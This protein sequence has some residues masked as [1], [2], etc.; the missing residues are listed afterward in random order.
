MNLR[1][2]DHTA[3][4]VHDLDEAIGRYR[5]LFHVLPSERAEVADQ[6][7]AVAFLPLGNSQIELISPTDSESGV[8]RFLERRG[9][10]LHHIAFAVDDIHLELDRLSSEGVEL[11]DREPRWGIHGLIAFVHPRGTG[12]VLV[13][14]VEH[15]S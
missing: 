9:E 15:P 14:L 3:I 5:R 6:R 10:G 2:I 12:G 1:R 8:A 13:E 7:I 4:A 11:I